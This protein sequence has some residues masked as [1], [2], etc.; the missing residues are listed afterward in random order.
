MVLEALFNPFKVKKKPW[1][2]FGAGMIYALVGLILSYFVFKEVAAI[3]MVFL[4]VMAVIP[5]F[6][7]TIQNEEKLDL[8]YNKESRLLKEHGKVLSYLLFLFFGITAAFVI[9]Y[10][11]FPS[12]VVSSVFSLQERAIVNV[13]DNIRGMLTGGITRFDVFVRILVNNIKVLFFCLVFSLLYGTGAMF[14]LTWNASVIA[15]AI[16]ALVK[17]EI[18]LTAAVAGFAG[19]SSYF[20]A[21]AFGFFRYMTH[22]IFEI[23]AYFV[24]GLAGG[25]VSIA[26]I[27]HNLNRDQLVIDVLDLVFISLG[28]LVV[29]AITEVYMTPLL[30]G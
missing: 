10:I 26:V 1:E 18:A 25:I 15:T 20:T 7:T 21:T 27:K 16:G 22:G 6:Y 24:M 23:A 11:F 8:R 12:S 5:L 19:L 28:L 14:I 3:L 9:A 2:M 13:N 30:F 17:K 29:A 4:V